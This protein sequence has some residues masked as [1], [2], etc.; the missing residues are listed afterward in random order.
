MPSL[1][2]SGLWGASVVLDLASN[3]VRGS[4]STPFATLIIAKWDAVCKKLLSRSL[5]HS[6]AVVLLV[7]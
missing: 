3:D 4:R 2:S 6:A 7:W 1:R 5:L